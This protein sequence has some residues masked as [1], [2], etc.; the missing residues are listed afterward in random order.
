MRAATARLHA[1]QL[2]VRAGLPQIQTLN[3]LRRFPY[4]ARQQSKPRTGDAGFEGTLGRRFLNNAGL[5][6]Q[7]AQP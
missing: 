1:K 6:M 4:I 7:P 5:R 3:N 2:S